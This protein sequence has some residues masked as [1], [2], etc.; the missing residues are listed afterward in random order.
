MAAL[1]KSVWAGS[2]VF[3]TGNSRRSE[4]AGCQATGPNH[5]PT[6]QDLH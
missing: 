1:D 6:A 3:L 2:I 5:C 4:L